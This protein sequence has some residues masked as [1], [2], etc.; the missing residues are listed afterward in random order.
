M[1]KASLAKDE[2]E[3]I[4]APSGRGG[5]TD[6]WALARVTAPHEKIKAG[7]SA[8]MRSGIGGGWRWHESLPP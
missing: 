3:C 1:R 5:R 4:Y 7:G 6:P 8:K 2:S